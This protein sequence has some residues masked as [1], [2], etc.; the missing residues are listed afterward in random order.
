MSPTRRWF[1]SALAATPFAAIVPLF[2]NRGA[3]LQATTLHAKPIGD[4]CAHYVIRNHEGKIVG[5]ELS[6]GKNQPSRKTVQWG[7]LKREPA[8]SPLRDSNGRVIGTYQYP[9]DEVE[10]V[11]ERIQ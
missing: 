6:W 7:A 1:L 5:E 10:Y 8:D 3:T 2:A 9:W 4:E 11:A